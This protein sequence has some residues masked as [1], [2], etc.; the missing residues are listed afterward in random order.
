M[1]YDRRDTVTD[2]QGSL[3]GKPTP[4]LDGRFDIVVWNENEPYGVI[5]VKSTPY[6]YGT[7]IADTKKICRA[8][9]KASKIRWGLIAYPMVL[10]DK[11]NKK[12]RQR[13]E[14]RTNSIEKKV[15]KE[16]KP[17]F[18]LTRR[19]ASIRPYSTDGARTAEVLKI[20]LVQT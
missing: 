12:G 4:D 15:R 6:Q 13:I 5:E 17:E 16:L 20:K 9:K 8:L 14:H 10:H 3:V 18:E 19:C 11:P 2:A 1:E 7:I